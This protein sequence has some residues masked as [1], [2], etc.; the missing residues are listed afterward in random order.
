[1]RPFIAAALAAT[2]QHGGAGRPVLIVTSTFREAEGVTAAL[3]S[4]LGEDEVAYYPAWETLPHERLSPRSDTVGR[5]LA[6]LRRLAGHA[7]V[8]PPK[9]IVAPIR[10]VLQPQVKGLADLMPVRLA[11]G[12]G[13]RSRRAGRSP[14]RCRVRPGRSGR[15]ARRVRR[16]RRHRRHLPAHRGAP[17]TGRL[18][19]RHGGGDP[20]LLGRRPAIQRPVADRGHR[21]AVPRA[22]ADRRGT[23]PRRRARRAAPRADR[24]A[25]QDRPG[26]RRRRHG[27]ALAGAGRRHGTAGRTA[28]RPAPTC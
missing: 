24:D 7:G 10:S 19:R 8:P 3:E 28:P 11:V 2:K 20:L 17:G 9:I 23:R 4:L 27:G 21:L 14:G 25:R 22:A 26:P 13:L 12:D 18:L 6:V 1:M 15:A 16:T 5:R